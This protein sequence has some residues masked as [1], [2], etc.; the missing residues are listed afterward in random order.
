[1]DVLDVGLVE[2]VGLVEEL[3]GQDHIAKALKRGVGLVLE[4]KH[5]H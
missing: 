4:K 5:D 3:V 2:L 1:V